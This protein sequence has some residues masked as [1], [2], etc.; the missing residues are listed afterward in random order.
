M[1][2]SGLLFFNKNNKSVVNTYMVF[3]YYFVTFIWC[4]NIYSGRARDTICRHLE[5]REKVENVKFINS[6]CTSGH[7]TII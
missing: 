1:H 2:Y 6:L 7:D 5:L 3:V 4:R